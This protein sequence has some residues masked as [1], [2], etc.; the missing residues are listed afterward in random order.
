MGWVD[1][2]EVREES[3]R[4]PRSLYVVG[5]APQ[6]SGRGRDGNPEVRKGS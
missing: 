4:S 6:K 3:G 5:R 2:K 1:Y